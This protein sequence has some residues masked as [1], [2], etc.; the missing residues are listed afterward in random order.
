MI[1]KYVKGPSRRNSG[2]CDLQDWSRGFCLAAGWGVPGSSFLDH[3]YRCLPLN[4]PIVMS[5]IWVVFRVHNNSDE[6]LNNMLTLFHLWLFCTLECH[7]S[8]PIFWVVNCPTP[9]GVVFVGEVCEQGLVSAAG[10]GTSRRQ[11]ASR[12]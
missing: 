10:S 3:L 11:M 8:P 1:P 5:P 7:L 12:G 4:H 6:H 9:K 2:R